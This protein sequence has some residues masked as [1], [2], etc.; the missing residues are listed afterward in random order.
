MPFF[1]VLLLVTILIILF[2]S[3][4]SYLLSRVRV[5]LHLPISTSLITAAMV[6]VGGILLA[7]MM[8][9][10]L[11]ARNLIASYWQYHELLH[12]SPQLAD[13]GEIDRINHA[14]EDY[15]KATATFLS[16]LVSSSRRELVSLSL[17]QR[18]EPEREVEPVTVS[19]MIVPI[20]VDRAIPLAITDTALQVFTPIPTSQIVSLILPEGV[21]FLSMPITARNLD[22][23][24]MR[25]RGEIKPRAQI[26][27]TTTTASQA[28][29]MY[30]ATDQGVISLMLFTTAPGSAIPQEIYRYENLTR[31]RLD[32]S[33]IT[34]IP[35]QIS[36]IRHDPLTSISIGPEGRG[37]FILDTLSPAESTLEDSYT[38]IVPISYDARALLHIRDRSGLWYLYVGVDEFAP[39]VNMI[40]IIDPDASG[41]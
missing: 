41:E 33:D 35:N 29:S 40:D 4:L 11:S 2:A 16:P 25:D 10:E 13:Q 32:L 18:P 31:S 22:L 20:L 6:A 7:A 19:D 17:L 36:V 39:R 14:I 1:L 21:R 3:G 9:G 12:Q 28:G 5:R 27:M 23:V 37:D 26:L 8:M 34:L 38:F 30:L 15:Q 24:M